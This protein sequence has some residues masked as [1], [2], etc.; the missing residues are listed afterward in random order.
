MK[1]K[2]VLFTVLISGLTTLGVIWGY[3]K[4]A[5][6]NNSYAGQE[7][8]VTPSNYHR[9]GLFDGDGAPPPGNDFTAASQ[10]AM[11][12]V[13]HIKAKTNAKQL[14]NS[15]P[16]QQQRQRTPFDD[17]FGNDFIDQFF[18]NRNNMYVP[19]QQAS[20]SGVI[21][22]EDGYIVTN[23]H[24][25]ENA[26]EV[27]ITLSNKKTY[28]A[29]VIGSDPAYDLAVIKIDAAG[30][31]FSVYGNSDDVKVGQWVL[32]LGYPLD[33]EATVT[34]GIVSAKARSIGL[35]KDRSGRPGSGVES[36]IQ[37]DAAVNKGNSGGALINT[38]G[39]L[40]G[41]NSAIFSPTGFY[42]GYSYAIPVN[43]VKKVVDD[44]IKYGNVQRGFMGVR[45]VHS[46]E[47]DE[48]EKRSLNLNFKG[49]G[50][51]IVEAERE[52]G[53]YA[54]GLRPGDIIRKVNN[55]EINSP[56][57]LQE[58]VG[59]LKPGDKV[60]VVY[61]RNGSESNVT[62]TLKNKMHNLDIVKEDNS[63]IQALGAD[64]V[65]LDPKK[66]REYGIPGGIVV[67]R[68]KDG[69]LDRQ[70]RMK[71]SFVIL[72]I[73]DTEVKSI[74]EMLKAIGRNTDFTISGFYPGYD[75]IYEY[76]VSLSE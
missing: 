17:F 63:A 20:G 19:E 15:L 26:D 43:I 65:T 64:F 55:A 73:N 56:S 6:K 36:F 16:R 62:V 8:G 54:A 23:N 72:K 9:A 74:E 27:K 11:P 51:V 4:W 7:K 12:T 47:I 29:K 18:G 58:A 21:I 25:I 2:Q 75:G 48:N 42:S 60:N 37:T 14:S 13:V 66:A 3:G 28:T 38:E 5:K 35:N 45:T 41:I 22:S 31:P 50:L 53:A 57:E 49:D 46:N 34:A 44:L 32:A 67:K 40:V 1:L 59:K 33:L 52:G 24:V 69:A 68:I 30:L 71:D 70:T 61:N 10:A 76:P 39:K